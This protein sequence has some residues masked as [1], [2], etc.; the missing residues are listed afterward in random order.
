MVR[1]QQ[2][3]VLL[4]VVW[5]CCLYHTGNIRRATAKQQV[6]NSKV[7]QRWEG[8]SGRK[9]VESSKDS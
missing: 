6:K 9:K 3:G 5:L 2:R 7:V 4:L 1:L 8:R